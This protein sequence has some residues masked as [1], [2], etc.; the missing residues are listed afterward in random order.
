MVLTLST[1]RSHVMTKVILRGQFALD[2]IIFYCY[3]IGSKFVIVGGNMARNKPEES[4]GWYLVYT[5]FDNLENHSPEYEEK[6]PLVA[7]NEE[8][9]VREATG[10]WKSILKK[11]YKGWDGETYPRNPRL[12][13][14]VP[15]PQQK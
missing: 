10:L 8:V 1:M 3:S 2:E 15:W 11:T 7:T 6:K 9:A 5:G 14:E 4:S 12:I 13:Y